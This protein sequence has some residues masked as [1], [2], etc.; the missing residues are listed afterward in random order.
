MALKLAEKNLGENM[1]IYLLDINKN[2]TDAWQKY[3]KSFGEVE[4]IEIVNEDFATF[5]DKHPNIEAVVSPANSFGLMDGGYDKAITDYFGKDLMKEV[6]R[7]IMFDWRGEQPVGTSMSVPIYNRVFN[8]I[9]GSKICQLIH[10]PSMRTPEVIKDSRIIY[11]CMRTTLIEA[12]RQQ[13][14]NIV[15]PAF[16]GLTGRVPCDEI[17]KMMYL[18]YKQIY[19]QPEELNWGYAMHIAKELRS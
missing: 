2:M 10:T 3:F 4:D 13:V 15:I 1:K 18:A 11:Q 6:Q 8:T 9:Y 7:K 17:A 12:L 5:M 14:G 16:G 19:N